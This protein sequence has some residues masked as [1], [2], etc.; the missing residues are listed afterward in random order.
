MAVRN[1]G[2]GNY[3]LR[4]GALAFGGASATEQTYCWWVKR[5]SDTG[6][7]ATS[8]YTVG[9]SYAEFMQTEPGG[10]AQY[11]YEIVS[12]DEVDIVGPT[13][14]IDTWYF[15]CFTRKSD[16]QKLY[17]G[18]EAGG[19]LSVVTATASHTIAF[20]FENIFVF[21]DEYD[22]WLN[23]EMAYMR[24]W[25]VYFSA[26]EADAEWRSTTPV[27][28]SVM[29]DLR[30]AAAASAGTD[31]SGNGYNFTKTGT[32]TD[33]GSNPTPPA[34]GGSSILLSPEPMDGFGYQFRGLT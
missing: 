22:E 1:S 32:L 34:S 15:F 29:V 21:N 28:A 30:L 18:T 23:G 26:A 6:A 19:T 2:S 7:N 17:Y 33:G 3:L 8:I 24:V 20:T 10:D 27:K 14:T 9:N 12:G 16:T 25:P 4:T 13:L 31:S 11:V 5:K